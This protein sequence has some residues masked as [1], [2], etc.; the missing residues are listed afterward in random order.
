M[1]GMLSSGHTVFVLAP[2][3]AGAKL[4]SFNPEYMSSVQHI[5][6]TS[7]PLEIFYAVV[8]LIP[9]LVINVPLILWVRN[10]G[11]SD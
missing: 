8:G 6:R 7:N 1:G 9:I 11:N 5:F 3:P 4:A 2:D 10:E